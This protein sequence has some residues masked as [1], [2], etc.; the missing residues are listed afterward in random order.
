MVYCTDGWVEYEKTRKKKYY[1]PG[2]MDGMN[3]LNPMVYINKFLCL[4]V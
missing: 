3:A 2:R 1:G 4:S